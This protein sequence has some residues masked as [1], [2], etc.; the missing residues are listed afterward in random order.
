MR[1]ICSRSCQ[2]SVFCIA[3]PVC[4]LGRA[5]DGKER[6]NQNDHP[7]TFDTVLLRVKPLKQKHIFYLLST[8]IVPLTCII[9]LILWIEHGASV[10]TAYHISF[11]QLRC[12]Q[13]SSITYSNGV[14]L[15]RPAY[16]SPKT[17]FFKSG[18]N[19][20]SAV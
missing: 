13:G 19:I 5:H 8:H 15:N 16:W 4:T 18:P 17:I 10:I 14:V 12:V 9:R 7:L 6:D 11:N 3:S 1:S 20:H 2:A